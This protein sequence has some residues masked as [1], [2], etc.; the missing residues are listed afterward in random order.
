VREGRAPVLLVRAMSPAVSEAT[1]A[2]VPLDG[3]PLAEQALPMVETLAGKPIQRVRLLRAIANAEEQSAAMAYLEGISNRLGTRGLQT[4][5]DVRT[6][7]PADAIRNAGAHAHVVILS[8]HGR[9]GF[10]RFRHGSV[11]E[12]AMRELTTPVLLIR[13]PATAT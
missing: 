5:L 4:D 7:D 8:T 2:L 9:G 3:S 6:E 12:R 11:A 10:D 13:A 1:T